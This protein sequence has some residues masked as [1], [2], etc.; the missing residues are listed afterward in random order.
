MRNKAVDAACVAPYPPVNPEVCANVKTW[1]AANPV[2]CIGR[3]GTGRTIEGICGV[4][5][6]C[7]HRCGN[8]HIST[9]F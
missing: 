7:Y 6:R 8:K 2:L 3:D 4:D 1:D 5:G 9:S